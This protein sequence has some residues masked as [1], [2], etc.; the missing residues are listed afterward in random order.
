[1][2]RSFLR[3]LC[4]QK[5][6]WTIFQTIVSL[7]HELGLDVI[8]EGVETAC[9]LQLLKEVGCDMAQGFLFLSP[10]APQR[11]SSQFLIVLSAGRLLPGGHCCQN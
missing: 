2:D 4:G 6:Q 8:A 1:M 9:Q 10:H 5:S 11:T 7:A 3:D